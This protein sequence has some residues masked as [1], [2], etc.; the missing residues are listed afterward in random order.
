MSTPGAGEW[1]QSVGGRWAVSAP[2]VALMA[3]A[4]VALIASNGPGSPLRWLIISACSTA[5]LVF[6]F[7]LAHV[8]VLRGR[9]NRPVSVWV[10]VAVGVVAGLARSLGIIAAANAL[11]E[12]LLRP[13]PSVVAA[14]V[15]LITVGTVGLA[16]LFDHLAQQRSRRELLRMRLAALRE[17]EVE[18]SDLTDVIT[19]AAY[20][21]MVAALDD[22]RD[23]LT[24]P[25]G[26]M[27]P[28]DR[29]AVAANLR[30]T[31]DQTLRPLSHKLYATSRRA[32]D[33]EAPTRRR[34]I[35][36]RSLPV[37]PLPSALLI[38]A[39]A[40]LVTA[41]PLAPLILGVGVWLLLEGVVQASRRWAWVRNWSFPIAIVLTGA[42]AAVLSGVVRSVADTGAA[43]ASGPLAA[44][45]GPPM[46]LAMVSAVTAL[47]QGEDAAAE[48]LLQ[49]V[50][51]REIDALVANR[52][53]ARVTR[54][55]AEDV[56][57]TMQSRLLA[58]AFAIDEAA[59]TNDDEAFRAALA[60]ARA[61]LQGA[62]RTPGRPPHDLAGSLEQVASLWKGFI[63]V[64]VV[65]DP[66]VPPVDPATVDDI[67][68]VVGEAL[69]NA[70]KHG[71]ATQVR[72]VVAQ[73]EGT[74]RIT[75]TDDG[76]GPAGGVPGLGSAWL[77][78]IAPGAWSLGPR[79]DGPG[80]TLQVTLPAG[81]RAPAL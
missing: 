44:A 64:Q 55:L 73:E 4:G 36:W 58:T 76:H 12:P 78:F 34:W 74:L 48:R 68:R 35:T 60:S 62:E 29:R 13:W 18:R 20:Q 51:E 54:A 30:T 45:V 50:N 11:G 79:P 47:L 5:A 42:A 15:V 67:A 75:A 3:L 24:Q 21:E 81:D 6:V 71:M 10:V 52:E 41:H 49:Q 19:H 2:A 72:V 31:V 69:A 17:Q 80:A 22:V 56:H 27:T 7:W 43:G 16:V 70:H 53:L 63:E 59:A 23:D 25:V 38:G 77:D 14:S 9:A 57:G 46:L 32:A 39:M 65:V 28:S 40:L 33:S 8:T 1:R 37:R 66:S 61:A 26:A